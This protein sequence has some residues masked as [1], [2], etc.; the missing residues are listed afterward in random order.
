MSHAS[1]IDT[2]I[3]WLNL[4]AVTVVGDGRR[5]RITEGEPA[6]GEKIK[7]QYFFKPSHAE[8]VLVMIDVE[9]LS[10]KPLA[11]VAGAIEQAATKLGAPYE[12]AAGLRKAAEQQVDEIVERVKTAGLSGR[13]KHWNVRYR[14]YRLAQI[15]KSEPAIPYAAFIERVV[16]MPTV[17]QLAASGRAI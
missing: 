5:C 9:G 10:G 16:T 4:T 7:H 3:D 1:L 12:T 6:E 8:L 13:L 17:R 14:Q 11:A 15:E 2:Y